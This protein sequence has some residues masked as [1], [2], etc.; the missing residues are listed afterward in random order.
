VTAASSSDP[1][2]LLAAGNGFRGGAM[3]RGPGARLAKSRRSGH[4]HRSFRVISIAATRSPAT[5][6]TSL[7]FVPSW[8]S[9]ALV[10]TLDLR[11]ALTGPAQGCRSYSCRLESAEA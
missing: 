8:M 10:R 11:P 9:K 7:R 4:R 2:E 3:A 6:S 5:D 1:F